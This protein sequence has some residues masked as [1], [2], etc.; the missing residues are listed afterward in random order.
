MDPAQ[1]NDSNN[2]PNEPEYPTTPPVETPPIETPAPTPPATFT[3]QPMFQPDVPQQ[4]AAQ[5]APQP[6]AQPIAP[7]A[8]VDNRPTP[9]IIVLQWLTYAFW[10]WTLLALSALTFMVIF[11]LLNKTDSGFSSLYALAAIVVLL[12]IS[13]ACDHFYQKHETKKKQGASMVV[14]VI[15]AVIFAL[16]AIGAL[17][18]SLFSAVQ[19]L[20]TS[21]GTDTTSSFVAMIISLLIITVLYSLTFFRTLNPLKSDLNVARIFNI[22][23]L[24]IAGLFTILAFVGPFA[25]TLQT[26]QDRFINDNLTYVE[27]GIDSYVAE[28][29]KLPESLRDIT[30]KNN[31]AERLIEQN[32][33]TYKQDSL[34]L[35]TG[36]LRYQ[37]CVTYVNQDTQRSYSYDRYK[38]EGYQTYLSTSGHAAGDVC[39]KLKVMNYNDG[40]SVNKLQFN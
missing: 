8:P 33:V 26:K 9:G 5:P 40:V 36:Y 35:E 20:M 28:N 30:V 1:N 4:T 13:L 25:Q 38:T 22:T 34:E 17:I 10:G 27:N 2:Q 14:M 3:P 37:L 18:A 21:A 19:L 7:V 32:L 31:D 29:N 16:F 24:S 12:P 39:Y 11:N 6:V 23:M 15:H